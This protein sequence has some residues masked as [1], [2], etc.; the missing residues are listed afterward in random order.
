MLTKYTNVESILEVKSSNTRLAYEYDEKGEQRFAKFAAMN[1]G[2]REED[3]Y[4][5]VR[6]RA[7]SSRVNKNNDGWPSKELS[8]SYKTFENRP[9]FIDHNNDDPKRTRGVIVASDLHVEDEEKTAALDPYYASAPEEHKPPTWIELLLE[10]DA[11]SFPKLAEHLKNGDIGSVSMGANIDSSVCSVCAHEAS[12]PNEY[13]DHIK[14]KG[15]TFEITA[16]N[17]EKVRKKSYED[18][19]GIN[20]FEIS[21]VFDPADPTADILT[22]QASRKYSEEEVRGMAD[23]INTSFDDMA[24]YLASKGQYDGSRGSTVLAYGSAEPCPYCSM[25][26]SPDFDGQTYKC[27]NCGER[28]D[29]PDDPDDW[30]MGNWVGKRLPMERV[31]ALKRSVDIAEQFISPVGVDPNQQDPNKNLNYIP[32]IDHTT[33]PQHVDTLRNDQRCPICHASELEAGADGIMSCPVCGHVQEPEPLNNPD[34]EQ[35]RD[36]MLRQDQQTTQPDQSGAATPDTDPLDSVEFDQQSL[37][38][39][40]TSKRTIP[41]GRISDTDMFTLKLR[42]TSKDEADKVLPAKVAR[43]EAKVGHGVHRG[44]YDAAREAGLKV[45]VSYPAVK[46]TDDN[47][48]EVPGANGIFNLFYAE[49][50]AM[51][52]GV[53]MSEVPVVIEA[54]TAEDAQ[55]FKKILEETPLPSRVKQAAGNNK[56][57]I[58]PGAKPTDEPKN[59]TVVSSPKAPVESSKEALTL[60]VVELD[61]KKYKLVDE[62]ESKEEPKAEVVEPKD[63]ADESDADASDEADAAPA[64]DAEAEADDAA[65]DREARLLA[66]FKLADMHVEMGLISAESKMAFI[67][68]LEEENL[69]QLKARE[70]TLDTVKSAG[71]SK[72]AGV[73]PGMKRVP[74]LSY[75]VPSNNGNGSNDVPI[76]ALFL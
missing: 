35:A 12:T 41:N 28:Y 50:S 23:R 76:E 69:E 57:P 39:Q 52:L 32:Q 64:E 48:V 53:D 6:C 46:T 25:M 40:P 27:E 73:R 44:V 74:R 5:Y 62:E 63:E 45:T 30:G 65:D 17:G 20:F 66:A 51:N 71:L 8:A 19:Y 29:G 2:I 18:C 11:E 1:K 33:A 16:D 55:K 34:L 38:S 70:T 59:E 56:K 43:I 21:F 72:R 36:N 10:V 75:A 31:A 68:E 42:T 15:V 24:S 67:A 54:A 60:D 61:G 7:I 9:V 13:C 49:E 4:L 14:K 58:L 3:G 26:N 47:S 37:N 22:K